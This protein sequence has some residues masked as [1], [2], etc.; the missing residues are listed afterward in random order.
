MV[1]LEDAVLLPPSTPAALKQY[2]VLG[3]PGNAVDDE[4]PV[5]TKRRE[6]PGVGARPLRRVDA[7]LVLLI[8]R[9]DAVREGLRPGEREDRSEGREE[10]MKGG[11]KRG[12]EE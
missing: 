2:L 6:D 1:A 7:V 12:E 10:G 11:Q 9:D 4:A 5:V 8:G 3:C